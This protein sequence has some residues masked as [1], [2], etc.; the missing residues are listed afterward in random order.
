[1]GDMDVDRDSCLVGI[2][3]CY[4]DCYMDMG[5]MDVNS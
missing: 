3:D 2:V 1:M 5:D 4:R